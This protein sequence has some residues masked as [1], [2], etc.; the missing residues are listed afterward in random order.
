[1]LLSK[2]DC[3]L[4]LLFIVQMDFELPP[5]KLSVTHTTNNPEI[6][7]NENILRMSAMSLA[8]LDESKVYV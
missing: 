3:S 1:M 2:L 7:I 6:S 4:K 8:K 5:I